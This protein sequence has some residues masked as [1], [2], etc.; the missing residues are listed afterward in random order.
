MFGNYEEIPFLKIQGKREVGKDG[1][2]DVTEKDE[3]M[4]LTQN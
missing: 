3:A 4:V 2:Q 1:Q